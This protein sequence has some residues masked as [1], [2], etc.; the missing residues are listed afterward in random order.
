MELSTFCTIF[1]ERILNI[2]LQDVLVLIKNSKN[3]KLFRY[4]NQQN[5][6]ILDPIQDIKFN[7]TKFEIFCAK[8]PPIVFFIK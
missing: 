4:Y 3:N 8:Y 5:V 7:N 2:I 6:K 1:T